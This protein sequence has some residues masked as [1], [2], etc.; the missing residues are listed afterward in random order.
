MTH[1]AVTQRVIVMAEYW[2]NVRS[3][4]AA[5]LRNLGNSVVVI[6]GEANKECGLVLLLDAVGDD[7]LRS[8]GVLIYRDGSL[9]LQCCCGAVELGGEVG[10]KRYRFD[11]WCCRG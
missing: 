2:S 7:I 11:P 6:R 9:V 4:W 5:V 1:G 10:K 8:G 3:C